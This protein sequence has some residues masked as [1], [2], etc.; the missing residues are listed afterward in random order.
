M[1]KRNKYLIIICIFLLIIL[2]GEIYF[3]IESWQNFASII[4]QNN[5]PDSYRW[6]QYIVN[7][8]L[9]KSIVHTILPILCA[10]LFSFFISILFL[11]NNEL[12]NIFN[13][14]YWKNAIRENK[15]AKQKQRKAARISELEKEL[16]ELKKDGE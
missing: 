6:E 10:L 2:A 7:E 14:S 16:N 5:R 1:V 3:C 12:S 11:D 8:Y 13:V 9:I 4:E 15:I